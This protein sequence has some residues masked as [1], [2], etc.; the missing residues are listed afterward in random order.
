ML[1]MWPLRRL[2]IRSAASLVPR[3][4]P[5]MLMAIVRW[6]K[7]RRE[8]LAIGDVQPRVETHVEVGTGLLDRYLVDIA[9]GDPGAELVKC[10]RGRVTDAPRPTGDDD[11]FPVDR[12]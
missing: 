9:D 11:D 7:E 6:V 12:S 5:K 8:R 2:T 4:T 10:L 3:M 1:I